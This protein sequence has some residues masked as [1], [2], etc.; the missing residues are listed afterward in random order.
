MGDNA[1]PKPEPF[2]DTMKSESSFT[3]D[4]RNANDASMVGG[5]ASEME[6]LD[7]GAKKKNQLRY[8]ERIGVANL[9]DTKLQPLKDD[10][11]RMLNV[12][13]DIKQNNV[14]LMAKLEMLYNKL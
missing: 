14:A 3:L 8:L 1:E 10:I 5:S 9:I 2:D 4:I 11:G 7:D 13:N 12:A 6:G